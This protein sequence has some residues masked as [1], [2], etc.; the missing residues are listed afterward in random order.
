MVKQKP[1]YNKMTLREIMKVIIHAET[2][3]NTQKS[4]P[5]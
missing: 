1:D 5:A 4:R 2:P 3:K